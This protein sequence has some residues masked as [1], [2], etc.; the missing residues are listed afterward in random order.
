MKKILGFI[1]QKEE[2]YNEE[3]N[4]IKDLTSYNNLL[5]S[6]IEDLEAYH[7]KKDSAALEYQSALENNCLDL[8][9]KVKMLESQINSL[10]KSNGGYKS[11]NSRLKREKEELKRELANSYKRTEI[12]ADRAKSKLIPKAKNTRRLSEIVKTM[13]S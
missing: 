12:P 1:I 11:N 4:E 10:K 5:C 7:L 13:N 8:K 9:N 6:R 2:D 3:Q